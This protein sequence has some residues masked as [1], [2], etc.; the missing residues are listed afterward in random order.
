MRRL[1]AGLSC[2]ALMAALAVPARAAATEEGATALEQG[3]RG[4]VAGLL[5]PLVAA[6]SVPLRVLPSGAGYRLE[7]TAPPAT[8]LR[9][10]QDVPF[11]AFLRPRDDGAW[12][13]EEYRMPAMLTM[14]PPPAAAPQSTGPQPGPLFSLGL[15][16]QRAHGV[17]DP[18]FR[19]QSHFEAHTDD[20]VYTVTGPQGRATT[21]LAA[22][23]Y[24]ATWDPAGEG[25]IDT[26]ERMRM[27]GY[28]STQGLPDGQDLHI[29]ARSVDSATR[30]TGV[31]PA[32]AAAAVRSIALLVAD[33][34]AR[35]NGIKGANPEGPTPAQRQLLHAVLETLSAL[36]VRMET[37]QTWSGLSITSAQGGGQLDR[38]ILASHMAAPGGRAEF[39]LRLELAGLQTALVPEGPLRQLIPRRLAIA[40]RIFGVPKSVAL[41]LLGHAIDAAGHPGANLAA[42]GQA[43]LATNP[44]VLSIDDLDIDL[45][46]SRLRGSGELSFAGAQQ[47]SGTAEL[48]LAGF[49]ALLRTLRQVPQ[50]AAVLPALIML[51]GLGEPS[52]AETLWRI[53]YANGKASVNGNDLSALF[54]KAK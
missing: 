38:A 37:E 45:G 28:D 54:P 8:P 39:G 7:I 49:D 6:D 24:S 21:H 30:G 20:V 22:I 23:D 19:T 31:N 2:L 17:F 18:S 12:I 4:W 44:V 10:G 3:L 34:M 46:S 43:L 11:T 53:D 32:S 33:V 1:L 14:T 40:P 50:A 5:A 26:R 15:G 13:I 42:Q 35:P 51:K 41:D 29:T 25:R 16:A 52:G 27:S 47:V 48:R 9:I 36:F